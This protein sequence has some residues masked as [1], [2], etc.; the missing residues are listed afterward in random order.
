MQIRIK[1]II[2]FFVLSSLFFS[3]PLPSYAEENKES[4]NA[5][6]AYLFH[7]E[8]CP[9]CAQEQEFIYNELQPKYPNL[10]V[11]EYEIY[12][13]RKNGTLLQ[14]VAQELNIN[15]SGVPLLIVGD[16]SFVGYMAGITSQEIEEQVKHCSETKCPDSVASL[17]AS[18]KPD[19]SNELDNSVNEVDKQNEEADTP[20]LKEKMIKL[21]ILGEVNA[22]SFSLPTLTIILGVLDGFNPCA[23]W[24]LIFLISLLLGM[25]N[26]KRM[27]LLG[28][29]FII[30]SA[31]VYFIFMAAWL[32]LIIFLGFIV[33][34][35]IAIAL[36]ALL[37]GAY[38]L[39][40]F[41]VNKNAACKVGDV[42]QKKKTFSKLT[43]AVHQHSIWLALGGIIALAFAV[44]LVELICSAGL[45]A[46][47]TQILALNDIPTWKNYLYILLYVFFFMLDDLI[48]FFIAMTT[49]RAT[50]ITTKYSR[51]SRLIG[52]ILMLIIGLLLLFKPEW[53]MFG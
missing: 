52:G 4:L 45:P 23:M 2:A 12:K 50:G 44:N 24:V 33:W 51:I 22:M 34:V 35:R 39:K 13:N 43:A 29:T 15:V 9:H 17:A 42:N 20:S 41:F 38:S 16:K 3:F 6:S 10:T 30:A 11:L 18:Y 36:I 49:L 40:D 48:I 8:G 31:S 26:R 21:P 14:K 19:K 1:L 32:N 27:W 37:G 25:K 7:G 46:V 5:L 53:L 28:L 47:Y